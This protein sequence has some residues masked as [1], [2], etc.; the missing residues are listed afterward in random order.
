MND[1]VLDLTKEVEYIL[2]RHLYPVGEPMEQNPEERSC[3][4]LSPRIKRRV[5]NEVPITAVL[6]ADNFPDK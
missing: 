2:H 6:S 5:G 4:S 3:E 1:Q